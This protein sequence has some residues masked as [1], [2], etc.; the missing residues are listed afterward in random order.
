M[1]KL[2]LILTAAA[3][4]IFTGCKPAETNQNGDKQIR[5]GVSIPAASHGWSAGVV[6]HAE[7]MKKKLPKWS[8]NWNSLQ[9]NLKLTKKIL[10]RNIKI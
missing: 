9:K 5:I 2:L 10:I 4:V 3:V 7:Q 8:N 6:W 1:K